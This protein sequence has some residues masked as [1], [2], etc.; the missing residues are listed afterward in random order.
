MKRRLIQA[1]NVYVR[2]QFTE[3]EWAKQ[4]GQSTAIVIKVRQSGLEKEVKG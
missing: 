3:S 1:S 4:H 2:I